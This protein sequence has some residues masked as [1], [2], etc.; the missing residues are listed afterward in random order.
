MLLEVS[1][2]CMFFSTTKDIWETVM[3]TY[4]KVQ[5]ASVVYEIKTKIS[6]TKQGSLSV[7]DHYNRIIWF[8]A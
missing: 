5:Y 7:T 3:K 2:N 6:S 1:K 4:S 8:V